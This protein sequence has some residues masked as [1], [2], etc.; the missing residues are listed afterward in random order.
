MG[1]PISFAFTIPAPMIPC[2]FSIVIM[3]VELLIAN[4]QAAFANNAR[5]W[6]RNLAEDAPISHRTWAGGAELF[7]W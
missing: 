5:W 6:S 3:A 1:W 4:S 2:A 7:V